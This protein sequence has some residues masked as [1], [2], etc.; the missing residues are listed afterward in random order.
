MPYGVFTMYNAL[1]GIVWATVF[2]L[3]GYM[4]GHDLPRLERHLG[5]ASIV[6]GAVAVL[7]ICVFLFG[8]RKTG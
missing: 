8:R 1:G 4:F 7:A 5:Q 3:L 2:G 6:L